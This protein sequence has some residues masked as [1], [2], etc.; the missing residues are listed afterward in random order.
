LAYLLIK[1]KDQCTPESIAV[2]REFQD[3]FPIELTSL[4]PTRELEFTVDLIP[5]AKPVS[6]TSYRMALAELKELKEHLEELLQ[7]GYI[8]PSVSPWEGP[9]LFVRKR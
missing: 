3:V 5:G 8:R 1:L 4:P 2:V 9:V 6:R 7:Q